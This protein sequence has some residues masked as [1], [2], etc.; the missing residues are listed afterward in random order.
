MH[1]VKHCLYLVLFNSHNNLRDLYCM[2]WG[3]H[4]NFIDCMGVGELVFVMDTVVI[5]LYH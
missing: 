2:W 5:P 1:Y 4:L 3:Q